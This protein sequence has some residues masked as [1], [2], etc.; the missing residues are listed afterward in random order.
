MRGPLFA[1]SLCLCA[2]TAVQAEQ[3][4]KWVDASGVVHFSATP[5]PGQK[6]EQETLRFNRGDPAAAAAAQKRWDEED[7]RQREQAEAAAK[8]GAEQGARQAERSAACA[9]AREI[10]RRLET[11]PAA[12]YR[13]EDGSFM[14]YSPE[15]VAGQIEQARAREQEYC[16]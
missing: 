13:R 4:Y 10:I 11:A 1:F 12:R 15:E 14:N 7:N 16:D 2:A 5:P 6:V 3:I 8:T 9:D